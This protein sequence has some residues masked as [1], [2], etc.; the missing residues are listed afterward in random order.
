MDN[1]SKALKEV[2]ENGEGLKNAIHSLKHPNIKALTALVSEALK[3]SQQLD[4]V[5]KKS[6]ILKNEIGLSKQTYLAKILI[7]ELL[8]GKKRLG[9]ESKPVVTVVSYQDK[10]EKALAKLESKNNQTS[11]GGSTDT[12]AFKKPRYVRIN[13]LKIGFSDAISYLLDEGWNQ[14]VD[15][16]YNDLEQHDFIVDDFV[17]NLLVFAAALSFMIILFIEMDLLY[18]KTNCLAALALKP[19]MGRQIID[20]CAAPGMKTSLL[21]ALTNGENP[22]IA[23]E[24]ST[25]RFETLNTILADLG[26][27]S[28]T[29]LNQNFTDINPEDYKDVEYILVDPSCSGMFGRLEIQLQSHEKDAE[30]IQRL[31]FYQQKLLRHAMKFPS[32]KR[33]VYS[34][35]SI[36]AEE[37]EDVI[38]SALEWINTP[39]QSR[40]DMGLSGVNWSFK[41]KRALP[42]WTHRLNNEHYSWADMC[43]KADESDFTDGFFVSVLE[44]VK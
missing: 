40:D 19:R 14:V 38:A 30:R 15:T 32:V 4:V 36:N 7:T 43:V 39:D 25:R 20:A 42:D 6:K 23:V 29:T 26:V 28:V 11:T 17:E 35:C 34:T 8:W 1:A 3:H 33:I 5:M 24:K 13:T 9:G 10:F 16:N 31:S 41:L 27:S 37:N 18:Y 12:P 2:E 44:R 21:A 22:I